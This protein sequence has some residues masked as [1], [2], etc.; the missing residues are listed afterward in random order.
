M[1]KLAINKIK[2]RNRFRTN[3]GDIH[4]LA[5]SIEE[6]GLLHPIVVRPDGRLIAGERRLAACKKLGWRSVPVT[7]V[8]LKEVIRGEFAENAYRKDFLPSEIEAIRRALLPLEKAAAKERQKRHGDTAP[9]RKKQSGKISRSD[10]RV[11]DRIASFAGIS[12]RTLEKI[13]AIVEAA[14]R[15]PRRFG[16]LVAE[17]DRYGRI[18]AAYRKLLRIQDE[19][20]TLAVKPLKGKFRT[21]VIDPPWDR[22]GVRERARPAY[23]TMTQKELLALPVP[24]WADDPAHLYLWTTNADLLDAFQ[25]MEVW[26]FKYQTMLTWMKPSFGRGAYFRTTTEH[27]LFGVR[28]HLLTQVRNI[29]T[30][31]TAPKTA[32]SE[33]P[34]YFYALVERA[35]YPPYVDI[36]AR[37]KRSGWSTWGNDIHEAA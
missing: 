34:N 13:Q 11:R 16:P 19:D 36:F 37:K 22:S 25:L 32:H 33:K 20:Q 15:Q 18:D 28:G 17:M 27:V 8:D 14:E 26:G 1:P 10:G 30:H 7:F 2:V 29:G 3:L 21:I 35:S 9:G 24:L 4:S 31:F 6:V 5:V 12:G 23:A